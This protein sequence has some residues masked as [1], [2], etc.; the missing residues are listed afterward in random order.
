MVRI[1]PAPG[2]GRRWASEDRRKCRKD[3]LVF[4]Q[5]ESPMKRSDEWG[6]LTGKQGEW[7]V[8]EMKVQQIEVTRL[9]ANA[10][11]HGYMQ[12]IRVAD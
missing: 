4:R 10:L 5:V 2:T 1:H 11:E 12:C 9:L 6:R 8:I 7:I 3:Y